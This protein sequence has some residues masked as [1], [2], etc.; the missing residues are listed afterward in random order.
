MAG[1]SQELLAN[2]EFIKL[3]QEKARIENEINSCESELDNILDKSYYPTQ[4]SDVRLC[5]K[6][7]DNLEKELEELNNKLH[8]LVNDFGYA[9]T[10]SK[11]AKVKKL[12]TNP[13][14]SKIKTFAILTAEN[15]DK[16]SLSKEDNYW[17]NVN[18][19]NQLSFNELRQLEKELAL[20]AHPYYKVKGMFDNVEHS[21]LIYNISLED[22]KKL[23]S[24]NEQQSFIY[25]RNE[26][27]KLIFEFWANKS[28]NGY[29]Y[30]LLDKKDMYLRVDN[31]ENYYTQIARDFK[32]NIPFDKFEW[33]EEDLEEWLSNKA[34]DVDKLINECLSD[35]IN[36]K[37]KYMNRVSLYRGSSFN[38]DQLRESSLSRVY[39]RLVDDENSCAIISAYRGEDKKQDE[40][41]LNELKSIV[42]KD[43]GFI[44]LMSIWSEEI[45]GKVERSEER[46]LLIPNIPFIE[47]F[48]LAKK[49]NQSSFIYKDSDGCFEICSNDF[50]DANGKY[51]SAGQTVK[52]FNIVKD[53]R[54]VLN[55]RCAE[56]IFE[57]RL[58]GAASRIVKGGGQKNFHLQEVYEIEPPRASYFQTVGTKTCIYKV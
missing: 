45:D 38:S 47:A 21:F 19:K 1:I 58:G 2:K 14:E 34:C 8:S 42:K 25:G 23:S 55:L 56:D 26:G 37:T 28:K 17:R 22:A 49:F 53:N 5:I 9:L 57:N 48:K 32:I 35:S 29:S 7:R 36:G 46:A 41:N 6:E 4:D 54:T 3:T 40:A 24:H 16:Q 10:E 31:A 43:Y 18:L 50:K 13:S 12:F 11:E 52:T 33:S 20:G 51:H 44:E 15:P 30:Q 27:G 39:R